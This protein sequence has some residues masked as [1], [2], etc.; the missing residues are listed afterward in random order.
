MTAEETRAYNAAYHAKHREARLVAFK[1]WKAANRDTHRRSSAEWQRAN[2]ERSAE[3]RNAYKARHPEKIKQAAKRLSHE[4]LGA[5][6]ARQRVRHKATAKP[7][8]AVVAIYTAAAGAELLACHWCST[9][10]GPGARHVDHVIPL[11]KGGVHCASNLV[12]ACIPCNL[13]KGALSPNE[14]RARGTT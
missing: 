9:E 14:F 3:I 8:A 2:P 13:K 10:T 1:E 12:I 4:A 6:A 11:A 7:D 5:H